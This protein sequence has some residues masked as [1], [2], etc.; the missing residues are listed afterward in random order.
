MKKI[1]F[2]YIVASGKK[3]TTYVGVTSNLVGRAY[4]HRNDLI[5]GFTRRYGVHDLVWFEQH[6][7]AETAIR[8]ESS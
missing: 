2:V 6:D 4:T 7:T 5:E 1:F 8:R 3:G